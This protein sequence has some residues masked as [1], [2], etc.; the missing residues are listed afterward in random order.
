M[1][2]IFAASGIYVL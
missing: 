1:L 2:Y